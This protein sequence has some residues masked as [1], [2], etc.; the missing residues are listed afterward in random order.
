M[1]SNMILS[2]PKGNGY[3][4]DEIFIEDKWQEHHKCLQCELYECPVVIFTLEAIH[5]DVVSWRK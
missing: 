4:E 1:V 5:K 3:F 2:P